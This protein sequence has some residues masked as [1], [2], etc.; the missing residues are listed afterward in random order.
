MTNLLDAPRWGIKV[1]EVRHDVVFG[2]TAQVVYIDVR[3]DAGNVITDAWVVVRSEW[4]VVTCVEVSVG[5]E[6]QTVSGMAS[7]NGYRASPTNW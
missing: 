4:E 5:D 7:S 3:T 1:V 6:T 2:E